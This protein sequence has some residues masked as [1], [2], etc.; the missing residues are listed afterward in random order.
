MKSCKKNKT[1]LLLLFFMPLSAFCQHSIKKVYLFP[2]QGSDERIFSNITLGTTYELVPIAYPVP[3]K[4]TSLHEYAGML[5]AQIDT[6]CK[7][8]LIGVSFGGMLCTELAEIVS[9]EKV[10]IISSA[11]CRS[12]LPRR[13]TVMK[14]Y[15]AYRLYPKKFVKFGTMLLQPTVEKG[16]KNEKDFFKDMLQKKDPQF[17]KETSTMMINWERETYPANIIHIHGSDDHV[18]NI[19]NIKAD[20]IIV[21]GTHIMTYERGREISEIIGKVLQ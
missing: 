3:A 5:A 8:A 16:L 11:K 17:L 6:T 12:E 14:K 21:N 9:P 10:I 1:V 13:Y 20:Y 7:F 18:L 15:P 4:K 19:K 2:G